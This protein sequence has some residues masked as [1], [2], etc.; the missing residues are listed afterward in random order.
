MVNLSHSI[1]FLGFIWVAFAP[2]DVAAQGAFDGR[3]SLVINTDRG[4]CDR[5]VRASVRI[6][7]GHIMADAS[8]F[9]VNG[10][11]SRTGGV[12]AVISAE[13][14]AA[15]GSGRLTGAHGGGVW[16]GRGSRGS[17]AG[18]WVAERRE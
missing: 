5:S 9:N 6:F 4:A 12:R 13:G 1:W 7:G 17:C 16:R 18:T 8:G 3:W 2:T 15:S 11:V 10:R 14:R